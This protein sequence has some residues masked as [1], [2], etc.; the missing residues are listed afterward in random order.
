MKIISLKQSNNDAD[1]V[2]KA[3]G[4]ANKAVYKDM[5]QAEACGVVGFKSARGRVSSAPLG[6]HW[7]GLAGFGAI[8]RGARD[9]ALVMDVIRSMA[10]PS[11][12]EITCPAAHRCGN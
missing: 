2:K 10:F 9:M 6:E 12:P 11:F 1:Y 7:L 8:T 5:A 3:E 4:A